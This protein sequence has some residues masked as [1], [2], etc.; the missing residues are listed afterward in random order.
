MSS[1]DIIPRYTENFTSQSSENFSCYLIYAIACLLSVLVN[2]L[3]MFVISV[4][5]QLFDLC[6]GSE[7]FLFSRP[8]NQNLSLIH[9]YVG[10]CMW[11]QEAKMVLKTRC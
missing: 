7:L 6:V 9:L 10:K 3:L 2:V 8:L 1:C 11:L 4:S 5:S